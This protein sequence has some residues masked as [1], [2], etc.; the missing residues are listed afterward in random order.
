MKYYT[1]P[2]NLNTLCKTEVQPIDL[3][4]SISQH[5]MVIICTPMGELPSLPDFGCEIWAIQYELFSSSFQWENKVSE[6]LQQVMSKY[7]PRLK[8]IDV[9]VKLTEMEVNYKFRKFP[10]IKKR[11]VIVVNAKLASTNEHFYFSTEVFVNPFSSR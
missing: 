6:S 11:A 3:G 8:N 4:K 2:L 1:A 5:L 9:S 10:D 7:E